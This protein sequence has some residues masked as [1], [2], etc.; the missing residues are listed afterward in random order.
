[1]FKRIACS[2][3]VGMMLLIP[4]AVA[5]ASTITV[6]TTL[7]VGDI[8]PGASGFTGGVQGAPPFSPFSVQLAP[9]DIFDFTIDFGGGQL[10][11]NN[12]SFIWAFSY[13]NLVSDVTGTG[14]LAL[15][16]TALAPLFTSNVKTDTEGSVHFGQNFSSSEFPG[17]PASVTF[18]G[19][20][21]LGTL[22]AYVDPDVHVRNYDNPALYFMADGFRTAPVPDAGS[23]LLLLGAGL[24]G[25]AGARRRMRK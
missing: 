11:I 15:L 10:T 2:V 4:G 22:D 20:R 9:G 21:Y 18:G 7:N 13:A 6:H 16:D 25:L 17:L 14:R 23:T 12:L 19:L 5:S 8:V 1:M 3:M 24:A